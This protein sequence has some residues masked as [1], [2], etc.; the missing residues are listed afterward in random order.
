[1]KY[2]SAQQIR[3][4]WLKFFES[5]G[6]KIEAS[7][8][9]IPQNDPTLLWINAGVAPLKKYFDGS[10]K[11]E[12][13]RLTNVQKCIRT[14]DIENVGKT[15]RHH[16]FFEM[17]GNFSIG[18][19]FKEEAIK[20][21][22]ELLTDE[23]WFGFPKDKLYMTYYMDDL[24]A[25]DYW[26]KAGIEPSHLIPLEGNFWE[27]G[28]GPC[29]PDTE[30]FFDRGITY[31]K[32]GK[33]LIEQDIDNERFIEIWN[34]VFSQ[35][36]AKDGLERAN[37]PELP[38]KNID[39][40]AGLER[41][42][43][44]L[45]G[46]QTNFETDLF[47]PIIKHVETIT[48][49][50]Y[51]GQMSFKVIADHVKALVFS[52]SDGAMLSNEGRGYVLRRLLRR[53]VKY[54][55]FLGMNQPFLY[56]LVD[57]VV[58]VMGAFYPN[59]EDTKDI[60]KKIILKEEEKFLETI[61][62]GE[63]Q[64]IDAIEQEGSV[65]SGKTAFKLYGTYGFPIELTLEYAEE[66][67]VTVDVDA[68]KLA[69]MEQK[70]RSR[71]ARQNKGSMKTQDEAYLNFTEKSTFI[72]YDTL[73]AETKVIKVFDQ[74]I[75]LE[76]TPFYA[77]SG[78]QTCDQGTINGLKVTN[79][80]K[81]PNGQFLHQV[82]GGFEEGD[83]VLAIVDAKARLDVIRNHSAAHLFHQAIK[84][85]LGKHANQQG[86]L[87]SSK[88]WRFDFNH[89]ETESDDK[90]IEIENLVKH[91][92]LE[93]P[94]DVMIKE[95]PI[96]EAKQ[97]GAMALFGEKYGNIVRVVNMGWSIELCGGTHVKNTKEIVDFAIC[98]YESIG[99][100]IYR[101]EGIT[102]PNLNQ[103]MK[104]FLESY[105]LEINTL[106]D[107]SSRLDSKFI[108]PKQPIVIGSYQ[109]IINYRNYIDDLKLQIKEHEKEL[110]LSKQKDVLKNVDQLI[111]PN[112]KNQ[113]VITN[114]LDNKV[115]KQL[116]DV[117]FDKSKADT[118]FLINIFQ[119][120]ASFLCKSSID[121][122]S[123]LVKLAAFLSDGSG[124]GRPQMAQGGT[125]HLDKIDEI[126]KVITS[127]L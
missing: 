64:L 106:F 101:M 22:F 21:G 85:V 19:Y 81:L 90:I 32:R 71:N 78:G 108:L 82:E 72:G 91:Y 31:D 96:D 56:K 25:K 9:L 6:H 2:M 42:A 111:N 55:R 121:Q 30:I 50:K 36:N 43:C 3:E 20:W 4:T 105:Q 100:G 24:D 112:L 35:F 124:G 49:V 33:E 47:Y 66:N 23:K 110:E 1:M 7:A 86:Q 51:T 69:L 62:E 5:K 88:S 18:D 68:F 122:A 41:F 48:G 97:I 37:Y 28:S 34:I 107:K 57:D 58:D 65:I 16:T 80:F 83:D 44:V 63:K 45:Q 125:Q 75:V 104:S 120:K 95:M 52:I 115:L 38:N 116:I 39:T 8:S 54:G 119:D 76:E 113:V 73:Q 109:D 126:V 84:D 89:F 79:V 87:V 74:G 117:I 102:G 13:P 114:D 60:V 12:S 14:N 99:S 70:Q 77:T 98:Q 10:E 127:K 92:I 27:I 103:K 53:A 15:A 123:N 59:L 93:K 29:G 46:A 17:L 11:P 67:N 61:S 26:I 40:G 118:I 94:L